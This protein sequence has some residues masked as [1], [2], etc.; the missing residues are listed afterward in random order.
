MCYKLTKVVEM[1]ADSSMRQDALSL[2]L[3]FISYGEA[4]PC[5]VLV[6]ISE[7]SRAVRIVYRVGHER[8]YFVCYEHDFC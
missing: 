2:C 5:F 3:P 1:T 4:S 8:V 7:L 6:R